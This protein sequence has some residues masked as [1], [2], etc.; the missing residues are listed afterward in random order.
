MTEMLKLVKKRRKIRKGKVKVK[1]DKT[2]DV[3][4]AD[5][6]VGTNDNDINSIEKVED[7][8]DMDRN[9]STE[10]GDESVFDDEVSTNG[11][12]TEYKEVVDVFVHETD[13]NEAIRC[14]NDKE[15]ELLLQ[16]ENPQASDHFLSPMSIEYNEDDMATCTC[17]SY[18][19][20]NSAFM[21][22]ST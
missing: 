1:S 22:F 5:K 21:F 8:F 12:L 19:R 15:I 2:K 14:I 7:I 17:C 11:S 20:V 18:Q 16:S 6:K 3:K 13:E 4:I 10:S 9:E